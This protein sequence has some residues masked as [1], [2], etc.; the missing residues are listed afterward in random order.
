MDLKSLV[1]SDFLPI[2]NGIFIADVFIILLTIAGYFTGKYLKKYYRDYGITAVLL[3]VLIIAI[4]FI[5][6]RVL[7]PMIFSTWSIWKFIALLVVIQICHDV[8]FYLFF[9]SIDYGKY[10][11]IDMFKDYANE[12][13]AGAIIGDSVMMILSALIAYGLTS[14]TTTTNVYVFIIIL[15]IAIFAANCV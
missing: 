9:R 6:A 4:G 1:V 15:Y 2:M 7:Y 12:V 5:I 8:L 13:A 3:D 10:K 11:L 14:V